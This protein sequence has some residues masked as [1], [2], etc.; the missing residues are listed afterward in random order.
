MN[1]ANEKAFL[2]SA[3]MLIGGKGIG[4]S[5]VDA[6]WNQLIKNIIDF[7]NITIPKLQLCHLEEQI[8][9]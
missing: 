7:T 6:E 8:H 1:A 4:Y 9:L 3:L 2:S 5:Y